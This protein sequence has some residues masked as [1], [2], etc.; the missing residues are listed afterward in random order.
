MKKCIVILQVCLVCLLGCI[1]SGC[2]NHNSMQPAGQSIYFQIIK[3]TK[4]E[5]ANYVIAN[6]VWDL[7]S[8]TLIPYHHIKTCESSLIGEYPYVNLGDGYF[9]TH[10]W[11]CGTMSVNIVYMPVL[12]NVKWNELQSLNQRWAWNEAG[13]IA[14]RP[15]TEC[16]HFSSE[17]VDKYFGIRMQDLLQKGQCQYYNEDSVLYA[18]AKYFWDGSFPCGLDEVAPDM[19]NHLIRVGEQYEQMIQQIFDNGDMKKLSSH[20]GGDCSSLKYYPIRH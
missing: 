17:D 1:C 12:I 15:F 8:D 5:Y 11:T 9:L 4:P 19:Y 3:F 18:D 13:V 10:W 14:E 20:E 16:Y 2:E 7:S 6:T